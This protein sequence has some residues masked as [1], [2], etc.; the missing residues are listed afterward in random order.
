MK[1][2]VIIPAYNE[3]RSIAAVVAELAEVRPDCDYVVVNDCSTDSTLNVLEENGLNRLN[4]VCNLGIGGGVQTGYR[5]ALQRGYD[6]A[7]QLDGDGQHDPR[8]LDAV[9]GPVERG[10]ADVCIGSRFIDKTGFQTSFMR[11]VGI[12]FLSLIIRLSCG[13]RVT[14]AT[15]GF[16]ACNRALIAHY[17]DHYAQD[18]PE[19]E[20]I[21]SAALY[22]FTVADVPVAM[23]Q[24]SAGVSSISPMKSVYFM[25]KVSVAILLYRFLMGDPK[26]EE[27]AP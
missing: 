25:L 1:T 22:G 3:E 27:P 12:R 18:Y 14:D 17:A 11:R 2:L 19:P 23:R 7:V 15:S 26:K 4:L 10:E 21:V 9:I 13:V 16:R 5:Y 6:I 24:R 8:Y 20:A